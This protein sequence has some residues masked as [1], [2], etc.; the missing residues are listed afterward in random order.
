MTDNK[1]F[2]IAEAGVNHNGS[3]DMALQ[4]INV[5]AEAGADAIKFQSFKA[6]K[7]VSCSALK[8]EY[9]TRNTEDS[10]SQLEMLQR[11]ELN[12]KQHAFLLGHCQKH[13]IEFMSTPFDLDSLNLLVSKINVARLKIPSGEIT[14]APF[15]LRIAKTGK[16]LILSTGMSTLN[17]VETALGVLAFGMI[18]WE[19]S[20]SIA[21]FKEAYL[22][23][24]GQALL[25]EKVVLLHCTTEYPAPIDEVNLRAMDTLKNV[26]ALPVGYSDHT[27]GI[28]V[29]IAAAARGAVIIEKH[30]TLDRCLP[31]PDHKASLEPG[32]LKKMV[33]SIRQIEIALGTGIKSPTASEVK[34]LAIVRRSL[35]AVKEIKQGEKFNEYNMGVKRPGIGVSPIAYWEYLGKEANRNYQIDE[36]IEP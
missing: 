10:E 6:D 4:L 29:P 31:G 26:F 30:L 21:A 1:V 11:L 15:L 2:I 24:K 14:N 20:P 34:N 25:N 13:G 12:E 32:E 33:D 22:S 9:Q 35:V 36:V 18:G 7:V 17:E 23:K 8:A 3:L 19:T 16:P 5:A 28:S 27:L